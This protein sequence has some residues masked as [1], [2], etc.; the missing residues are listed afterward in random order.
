MQKLHLLWCRAGLLVYS[1]LLLIFI[2]YSL[3]TNTPK[4][5]IATETNYIVLKNGLI[6]TID[7]GKPFTGK[8][9][10]VINTQIMEYDVVKG[11]KNGEFTIFSPNGKTL[12][13]GQIK[14]N[15]NE[16]LW[17]YFYPDGQL[18]SNGYFKDDLTNDKWSWYYP[19]GKLKA[20]GYYIDG[21][22]NGKWTSYT[23]YGKVKSEEVFRNDV[24]VA[25]MQYKL[26]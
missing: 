13:N 24:K 16:G 8:V 4:S 1:C 22:K 18:E 17:Q 26:S 3:N 2:F 11:L 12:I 10:D 19:D 25:G 7:D 5:T 9:H 20:T 21:K 14:D 23:E 15:K 6:C